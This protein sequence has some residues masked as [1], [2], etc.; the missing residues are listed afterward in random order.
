MTRWLKAPTRY[1]NY[2]RSLARIGLGLLVFWIA[3]CIHLTRDAPSPPPDT[4]AA[5]TSRSEDRA[6]VRLYETVIARVRGGEPYYSAAAAA[7]RAGNY[8]LRPF[9][10]FRL[11]TLAW[12]EAHLP[13]TATIAA[14]FLLAA[15]TFAAWW[16]R[17]APAF[18]RTP[19]RLIAGAL[20]LAGMTRFVQPQLVVF[21]EVW[22]S[23]LIA[24]SLAL[25]RPGRWATSVGVALA[26][27]LVR[28]TAALFPL[29]M[30]SAA[31][32]E[33]RRREAAAWS[34]VLAALAVAL[35]LHAQAVAGVVLPDDPAS[36]GWT[37]MHGAG[38]F[39]SSVIA[40]TGLSLLPTIIAA[41]LIVLAAFGWQ[42]WADPMVPRVQGLLTAYLLLI[43][44]AARPDTWYWAL[45]AAVPLLPGLAFAPDGLRDLIGAARRPA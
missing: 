16:H 21:H 15:A 32:I 24:L 31:L 7:L 37:G 9:V 28:E 35:V 22:A 30:A 43:G 17:L 14:V 19:P 41:T 45:F 36:P 39:V 34:A 40:A 13:R 6:D 29:V 23:L 11:P 10:T 2:S 1:A 3:L 44:F 33:G 38:L 42:G 18:A 20:V 26:A 8:P 27:V 12:I 5:S 4:V 25:W